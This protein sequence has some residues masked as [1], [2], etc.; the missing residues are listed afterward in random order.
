MSQVGL[1]KLLDLDA[2]DPKAPPPHSG[3]LYFLAGM[4]TGF[5]LSAVALQATIWMLR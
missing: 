4:A 3:W 2:G 1:H 5:S